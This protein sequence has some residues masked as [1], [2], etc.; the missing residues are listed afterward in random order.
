MITCSG[1]TRGM[2]GDHKTSVAIRSRKKPPSLI[3]NTAENTL[4]PAD[5]SSRKT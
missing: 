2:A 1:S 3:T 5:Y 4:F